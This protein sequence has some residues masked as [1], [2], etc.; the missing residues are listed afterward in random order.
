M[1]SKSIQ[2]NLAV[3]FIWDINS[4]LLLHEVAI[5]FNLVLHDLGPFN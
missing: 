3:L 1:V 4:T 5:I 2:C